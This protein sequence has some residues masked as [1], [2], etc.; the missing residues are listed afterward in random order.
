MGK[1][2]GHFGLMCKGRE[3]G[4]AQDHSGWMFR[5]GRWERLKVI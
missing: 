4:K 2:Q 5:E 1:A 3:T